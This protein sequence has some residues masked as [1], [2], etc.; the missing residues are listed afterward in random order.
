MPAGSFRTRCTS[1]NEG[2]VGKAEVAPGKKLRRV[3][4]GVNAAHLMECSGGDAEACGN[5]WWGIV[6]I[7]LVYP[8][9]HADTE[10][11]K[12]QRLDNPVRSPPE[13]VPSRRSLARL[14]YK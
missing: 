1:W 9:S 5:S 8:V 3:Q 6:R 10:Q 2:W 13:D 7:L 14:I 4:D 12:T 11:R